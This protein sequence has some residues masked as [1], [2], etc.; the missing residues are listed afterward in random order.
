MLGPTN[1]KGR[2]H[3]HGTL[4]HAL[5]HTLPQVCTRGKYEIAATTSF[6]QT[7][8]HLQQKGGAR[9]C[10]KDSRAR[11]AVAPEA[12]VVSG[13]LERRVACASNV[14]LGLHDHV[15]KGGLALVVTDGQVW[16]GAVTV[17]SGESGSD[18]GEMQPA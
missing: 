8:A 1:C 10:A 17:C 9:R 14:H 15:D 3:R 6:L 7:H 5:P 12:E 13:A 2:Q 11:A 16:R 4:S 18:R